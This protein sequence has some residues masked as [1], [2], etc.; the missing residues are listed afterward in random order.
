MDEK[1]RTVGIYNFLNIFNDEQANS[2]LPN[3][4]TCHQPFAYNN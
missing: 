1:P 4:N 3:Y 2:I